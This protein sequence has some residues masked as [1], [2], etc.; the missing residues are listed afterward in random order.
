MN[1]EEKAEILAAIESLGSKIDARIS[2]IEKK[3]DAIAAHSLAP[4]QLRALG[5]HTDPIPP[6]LALVK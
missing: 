1:S 3:I 2:I 5:I 6:P 4:S